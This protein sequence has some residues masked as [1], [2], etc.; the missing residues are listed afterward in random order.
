MANVLTEQRSFETW[1]SA[2]NAPG[3]P[4]VI[5]YFSCSACSYSGT[6]RA[7]VE[8]HAA[9]PHPPEPE[10]EPAITEAPED[11]PAKPDKKGSR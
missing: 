5:P 11:A 2:T 7:Y 9:G 8:A 1:S 10:A 3:A 4:T 6:D